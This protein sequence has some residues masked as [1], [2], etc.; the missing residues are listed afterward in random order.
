LFESV[1]RGWE[2]NTKRGVER[3]VGEIWDVGR[4]RRDSGR[5]GR[6]EG[7]GGRERESVRV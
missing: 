3:E 4:E 6:G 5:E 2:R 1:R 7:G